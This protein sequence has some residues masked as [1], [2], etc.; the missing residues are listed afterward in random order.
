[1]NMT[2]TPYAAAIFINSTSHSQW[3]VDGMYFLPLFPEKNVFYVSCTPRGLSNTR[4]YSLL[5]SVYFV[6]F[7]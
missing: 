3:R 7:I 4:E 2:T 1:M 5:H 6:R